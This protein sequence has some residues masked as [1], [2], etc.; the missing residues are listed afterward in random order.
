[1]HLC[2]N[3][4]TIVTNQGGKWF[5]QVDREN[6][7]WPHELNS[8]YI[9][10][11]FR[12]AGRDAR[13]AFQLKGSVAKS[14]GSLEF[15][16]IYHTSSGIEDR[17]RFHGRMGHT[18]QGFRIM[19]GSVGPE[20][21][22]PDGKFL[23]YNGIP[24]LIKGSHCE[25]VA[26]Y[27]EEADRGRGACR[28]CA[29]CDVCTGTGKLTGNCWR[30]DGTGR[31]PPLNDCSKCSTTGK[32][33]HCGGRGTVKVQQRCPACGGKHKCPRCKGYTV[34]DTWID[35]LCPD[36]E[37]CGTDAFL[38]EQLETNVGIISQPAEDLDLTPSSR[39][40]VVLA[41]KILRTTP[42]ARVSV[43][44]ESAKQ[45]RAERIGETVT[46]ALVSGGPIKRG[47]IRLVCNE[48]LGPTTIAIQPNSI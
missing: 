21:G 12:A 39:A 3:A 43:V 18:P 8:V 38:C 23:F 24:C 47:R 41:A 42:F 26:R 46:A 28:L 27:P 32:C 29:Q 36:C 4:G 16:K 20:G 37:G 48:T 14:D 17:Y 15:V 2:D 7:R 31:R 19:E 11:Q 34:V 5:G 44:V 10:E 1:M 25:C 13:G 40:L 9:S 6:T 22:S 45:E 30:C 35:D 33:P